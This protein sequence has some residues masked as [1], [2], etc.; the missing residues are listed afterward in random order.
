MR[1]ATIL[2]TN[3][4]NA[5]RIDGEVATAI[6]GYQDVGELLGAHDWRTIAAQAR[7]ETLRVTERDYG[8]LLPRPSKVLCVGLNYRKHILEMGRPLPQYPTVFAKFAETL[9]EPFADLEAVAE[10]PALD[11]EGELAIVI[12]REAYRVDE[13]EAAEYIAGYSIANDISMRSWQ[14][15][16]NEWLQGKMW[17]RST[18]VG[19][20]L[21]TFEE[22]SLDHAI[23]TTRV[24]GEVVQQES[25]GDLLFQPASLVA[26]L[27]TMIPL[28]PGDIV[29]TGT[30]GGVG[31]ARKPPRYLSAGDV[32]EVEIDGIGRLRNR[33]VQ[34]G[35]GAPK[36]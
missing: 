36:Q 29:L 4:R 20:S 27:S 8:M 1:L 12:G 7:G 13:R 17:A 31:H 25:T 24:N 9:T 16:T 5:A 23:L 14:N 34:F 19:P 32:V 26:Y 22:F 33:V 6:E 2:F 21:V 11:W 10:D 18:P 30:P 3:G 28:Q 15:R 35:T